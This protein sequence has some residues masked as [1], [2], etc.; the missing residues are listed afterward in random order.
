M[1]TPRI[2]S[3]PELRVHVHFEDLIELRVQA[4]LQHVVH[5]ADVLICATMSRE[6]LVRG[7]WLRE[8]QHT[9]AVPRLRS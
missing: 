1:S 9:T 8:G 7:E 3:A 6:P 5:A 2:V 4:D